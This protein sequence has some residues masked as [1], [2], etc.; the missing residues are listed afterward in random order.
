[1]TT[2]VQLA[3]HRDTATRPVNYQTPS[4]HRC[5]DSLEDIHPV[6][7]PADTVAISGPSRAPSPNPM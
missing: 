4:S 1:M 3:Q 5:R 7:G 2:P 6:R